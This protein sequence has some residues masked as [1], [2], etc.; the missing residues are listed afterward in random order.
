MARTRTP[1]GT[2]G[3]IDFTTLGPGRCVPGPEFATL[4][5]R[6]CGSRPGERLN[7]ST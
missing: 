6:R 4:T 5:A 2:F 1:I 3:D 7:R